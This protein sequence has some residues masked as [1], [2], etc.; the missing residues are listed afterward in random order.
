MARIR[1]DILKMSNPWDPTVL[2]YARAVGEMQKRPIKDPTSWRYLAAIHGFDPQLWQQHG[3]LQ[4]G[5][6]L[7]SAAD[8][9]TY[10]RQCQ[11]Q[12]WYFMPWHRG[13]L[14]AFAAWL[15][16]SAGAERRSCSRTVGGDVVEY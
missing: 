15:R 11:H 5:E 6:A 13:Y 8:Q 2:W 1:K 12:S 14:A 4:A 7:P 9:N 10:W 16:P 3:Y